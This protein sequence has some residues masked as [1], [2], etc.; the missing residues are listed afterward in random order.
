MPIPDGFEDIDSYVSQRES[1]PKNAA[2]VVGAA[3]TPLC[4]T[5]AGNAEAIVGVEEIT[6]ARALFV[7][8]KIPAENS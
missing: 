5:V 4:S 1:D 6:D 7:I 8:V 2:L 3:V